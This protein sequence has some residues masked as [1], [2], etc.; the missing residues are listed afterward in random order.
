MK[1]NYEFQLDGDWSDLCERLRVA[2]GF[3]LPHAFQ[4][5]IEAFLGVAK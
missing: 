1:V 5:T 4:A 2:C 3:N